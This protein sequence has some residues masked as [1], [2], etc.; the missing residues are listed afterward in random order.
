MNTKLQ[1][2]TGAGN[3]TTGNV[4]TSNTIA[5]G[6]TKAPQP[7]NKLSIIVAGD[8]MLNNIEDSFDLNKKKR[9]KVIIHPF[10]GATV[11]DLKDYVTPLPGKNLMV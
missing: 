7:T 1:R 6:C 5:N 4:V 10:P 2:K 9:A 3:T 11:E 8:S